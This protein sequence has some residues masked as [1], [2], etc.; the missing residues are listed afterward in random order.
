MFIKSLEL[1]NFKRFKHLKIVFPSDITVIKGPNEQGKSTIVEA[2]IAA[3][4]YDPKKSNETIR[5]LKSWQSEEFYKISAG[6]E[7]EGENYTL[8]KDFEKKSAKLINDETGDIVDDIKKISKKISEFGGYRDP[9]LFLNS[10]CVKQGELSFADKKQT[11]TEALQSIV[12]GGG[13]SISPSSIL[14]RIASAINELERGLDRGAAKN[15]GLILRLRSQ[16]DDAEKALQDKRQMLEDQKA[17]REELQKLK[18]RL[19]EVE[20]EL[21][22]KED[23]S[24]KFLQVFE[25]SEKIESLT[26]EY[27]K[28]Q[29]KLELVNTHAKELKDIETKLNVL[30]IFEK[31]DVKNYSRMHRD[32]EDILNAIKNHKIL[33]SDMQSKGVEIK[34]MVNFKY[35]GLI[36]ASAVLG[37]LGLFLNSVFYAFYIVMIAVIF[38][39]LVSR[40]VFSRVNKKKL[41]EKLDDLQNELKQKTAAVK[42]E[43]E[44][45]GVKTLESAEKGKEMLYELRSKH[46]AIKSKIEGILGDEGEGDLQNRKRELERQIG[47][48]E[49]KMDVSKGLKIPTREEHIRI[50]RDIGILKKTHQALNKDAALLEGKI[51]HFNISSDET[52]LLEEKNFLIK[53]ELDNAEKRSKILKILD[54]SLREAQQ[55]SFSSIRESVEE[56]IGKFLSE[57]TD[58]KYKEVSTGPEMALKVLS[59]EKGDYIAPEG[60]LSKGAIEQI[61]LVARFALISVLFPRDRILPRPLVILDDPFLSFDGARKARTR[62]ILKELSHKFQIIILTCSNDYDDWGEVVDLERA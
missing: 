24:K 16:L 50:E 46:A 2:L 39:A 27:D 54:E 25:S 51:S 17:A 21:S 26:K 22:I 11:L 33:I 20:K 28:I 52:N 5:N 10:S 43:L 34:E 4:F 47:V 3:L 60:N 57:I 1:E 30:K 48:E 12:S 38:W 13:I 59:S 40:S 14:K 7:A 62:N 56:Y 55:K 9:E 23:I 15:P 32:Y 53:E 18:N 36:T 37:S 42:K 44:Q 29:K 45:F 49:S 58:N 8:E 35:V 61:Y 6:F 19:V 31:F 41:L